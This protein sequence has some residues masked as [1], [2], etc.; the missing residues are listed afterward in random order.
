M[1]SFRSRKSKMTSFLESVRI[2]AVSLSPSFWASNFSWSKHSSTWA[3]TPKSLCY[4][5]LCY[6]YQIPRTQ[7]SRCAGLI[8]TSGS[9]SYLQPCL[10]PSS[11]SNW[12][13]RIFETY[14]GHGSSLQCNPSSWRSLLAFR[15]G[16]SEHSRSANS[17]VWSLTSFWSGFT[18]SL[19]SQHRS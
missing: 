19:S 14:Y 3:C 4:Y 17:T 16:S 8:W 10:P 6:N 18:C 11:S 7:K 9:R 12:L 1:T 13:M 2:I 5:P 15:F